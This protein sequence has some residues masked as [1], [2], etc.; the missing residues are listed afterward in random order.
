MAQADTNRV[1]VRYATESTWATAPTGTYTEIPINSSGLAHN[2]QTVV[3]N[4]LRSDRQVPGILDVGADAAG[5]LPFEL[6]YSD[7]EP[8]IESVTGGTLTAASAVAASTVQRTISNGTGNKSFT[9]EEE[10]ADVAEF[11]RF[12][13]MYVN[14]MS[15]D[16]TAGRIITGTM[17]FTGEQGVA[18]ASSVASGY[19]SASTNSIMTASTN[20]GDLIEG[21]ATLTTAIQ[22]V[23]LQL[24]ANR[25]TR[26]KVGSRTAI[27]VRAGRFE[28][29]GR[30]NAY[31]EDR[32]LLNKA[33]NHT[34]TSLSIPITDSNG[35]LIRI[36]LP[37]IFLTGNPQVRGINE[38]VMIALDF[39]AERD[40]TTNSMVR[41]EFENAV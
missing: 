24:N 28:V 30:L 11:F 18:V 32:T 26:M 8:F 6:N 36:V 34:A 7:F 21:G 37:R 13:G 12:T 35:K 19:A 4:R 15:F 23:T 5:D 9:L 39:R 25:A 41:F 40:P 33:I 14:Q 20:V 16:I 10:F 22:S 38:D 1:I 31:F 29:S 27:G 2:K 17:G 3:S